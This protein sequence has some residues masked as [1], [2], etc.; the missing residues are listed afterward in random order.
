MTK[1]KCNPI[2]KTKCYRIDLTCNSILALHITASIDIQ[3]IEIHR[4]TGASRRLAGNFCYFIKRNGDKQTQGRNFFLAL[5]IK[6][7]NYSY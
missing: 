2:V 3:S 4:I 6:F 5:K 1:N 7:N